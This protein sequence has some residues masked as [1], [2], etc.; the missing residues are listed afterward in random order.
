MIQ[1]NPIRDRDYEVG[2]HPK[3]LLLVSSIRQTGKC[4]QNPLR[5]FSR[6]LAT[7]PKSYDIYT[8]P[9]PVTGLQ[10]RSR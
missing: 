1:I 9:D 7:G 8:F 6:C 3:V 2:P 10:S 5:E 4:H